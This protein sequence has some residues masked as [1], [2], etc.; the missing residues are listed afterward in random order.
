MTTDI[1]ALGAVVLAAI[2]TAPGFAPLV[3]TVAR[4]F[5]RRP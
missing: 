2:V 1:L 4:W 5:N 3:A